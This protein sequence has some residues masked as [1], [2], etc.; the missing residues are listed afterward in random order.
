MT[1]ASSSKGNRFFALVLLLVTAACGPVV[2]ATPPPAPQAVRV[3]YPPSLRLVGEALN[4][5]AR[6]NPTIALLVSEIPTNSLD[7]A[8]A[9]LVL[10]FGEPPENAGF[11][12]PLAKEEIVWIVHPG[13]PIH[14][15]SVKDV[16]ALFSGKIGNW[17]Q[18]VEI[19]EDVSVWAYPSENELQEVVAEALLKGEPVTSFAYLAP[20]PPAMLAA[21]SAERGAIGFLPRAWMTDA[22]KRVT[23]D[24]EDGLDLH[25]PV[26]ALSDSPPTGAVR[27]LLACLQSPTGRRT[28]ER[29]YEPWID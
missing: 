8:E 22:V 7:D 15:L 6:A 16:N 2:T 17:D 18:L 28:L 27:S 21:V 23:L 1:V 29:V 26:L 4:S 25:R 20:D 3:A 13:N 12:A 24:D 14:T 10:W 19:D 5:C 9:D 11:S